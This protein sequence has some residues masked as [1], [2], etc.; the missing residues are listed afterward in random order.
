MAKEHTTET[1]NNHRAQSNAV[2]I[3]ASW[4]ITNG[5]EAY[6][7]YNGVDDNYGVKETRD[8]NE[9]DDNENSGDIIVDE[10]FGNLLTRNEYDVLRDQFNP[11]DE[12]ENS[13]INI[14]LG[15]IVLVRQLLQNSSSLIN[16]NVQ[17][18][19]KQENKSLCL[20]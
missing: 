8:S 12:D 9:Q 16:K 17:R 4:M 10:N 6:E 2:T 3:V 5:Y 15:A 14:F 1:W 20:Y 19:A 13:G 11:T 18:I 7:K